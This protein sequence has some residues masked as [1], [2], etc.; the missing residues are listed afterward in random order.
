[1]ERSEHSTGHRE[2]RRRAVVN[3]PVILALAFLMVATL[4]L[5]ARGFVGPGRDTGHARAVT[6]PLAAALTRAV[7]GLVGVQS[8]RPTAR[9]GGLVVAG[10]D[11]G[12]R[13]PG[14]ID[15]R[16]VRP[17]HH[18]REALLSLPPPAVVA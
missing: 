16:A 6:R 2:P 3:A 17:G 13:G 1:M 14:S 4:D 5:G 18:V 8:E 15:D 7:R 10:A 12:L 9:V 11:A